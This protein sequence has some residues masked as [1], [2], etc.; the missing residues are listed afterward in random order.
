MIMYSIQCTLYTVHCQQL[1]YDDSKAN[2][3]TSDNLK[4][5]GPNWTQL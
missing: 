4:S 1:K 2:I 5:G 3:L